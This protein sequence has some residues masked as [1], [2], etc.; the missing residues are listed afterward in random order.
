MPLDDPLAY[1]Q[2]DPRPSILLTSVQTLENHKNPLGILRIDTDPVVFHTKHPF[3]FVASRTDV[4]NRSRIATELERIGNLV[5]KHLA[6]LGSITGNG[7]QH[8]VRDGCI[9]ILNS[10]PQI[11]Q[12]L[13]QND[14]AVLAFEWSSFLTNAGIRQ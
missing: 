5:L 14:V 11:I 6:Q 9:G 13:M 12:S 4:D 3:I 2:P 7:G 10:H 8:I 1:R